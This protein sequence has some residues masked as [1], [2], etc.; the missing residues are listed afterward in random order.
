MK[1]AYI[2]KNKYI[3]PA[4]VIRVSVTEVVRGEFGVVVDVLG[5]GK[6]D[7]EPDK[8]LTREEAERL[9][10]ATVNRIN[11]GLNAEELE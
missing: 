9:M 7:V 3:N 10:Q 4:R 2:A 11:A 8:F 6:I 1:L 5:A